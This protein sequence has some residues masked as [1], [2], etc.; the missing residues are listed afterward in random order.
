MWEELGL[1]LGEFVE[2][3]LGAKRGIPEELELQHQGA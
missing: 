2:M 3:G 1:P